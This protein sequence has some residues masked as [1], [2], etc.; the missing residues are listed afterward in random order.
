MKLGFCA[1]C[2]ST[3]NLEHHHVL[4]RSLGGTD[5]EDNLL[6][7]CARRFGMIGCVSGVEKIRCPC[8][9]ETAMKNIDE[10]NKHFGVE[11]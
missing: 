9:K 4:P 7:L 6:T 1:L 11:E 5:D 10:I 8:G 3:D 2:G